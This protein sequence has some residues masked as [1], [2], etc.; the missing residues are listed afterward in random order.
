MTARVITSHHFLCATCGGDMRFSA[1]SGAMACGHCGGSATLPDDAAAVPNIKM[2]V[3]D[4]LDLS[5]LPSSAMEDV[6]L[7][8]CPD[9]G[10]DV[11]F[12]PGLHSTD[13]PFCTTPV[14]VD[15]GPS[16]RIKPQA[17]LPF[18]ITE[19]DARARITTWLTEQ[20]D[21]PDALLSEARENDP[22]Q[23]VCVPTWS[24]DAKVDARYAGRAT[25]YA[26]N[27]KPGDMGSRQETAGRIYPQLEDVQS[28]PPP[29]CRARRPTS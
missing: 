23:G 5:R 29:G 26:A 13:C 24:F 22:L 4:G 25:I 9:C 19:R 3:E 10:A 20:W 2:A 16:R 6:R 27:S 11:E 8:H 21:A 18:Q 14:V 17:V 12:K 7:A 28:S 15:T 1:Q